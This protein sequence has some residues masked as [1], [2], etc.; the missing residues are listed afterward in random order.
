MSKEN[1]ATGTASPGGIA[2][3]LFSR[4]NRGL[5]LDI[6]V[7]LVNVFLMWALTPLFL[8]VI[9]RALAEEPLAL[10]IVFIMLTAV[11]VLPPAGAILKRHSY[12]RR[13]QRKENF[14]IISDG[15]AGCFFN[16][17]FYFC[18]QIVIVSAINAFVVHYL[19]GLN[20]PGPE[21]FFTSLF[22][23]LVLAIV[24]TVF[25][26]R[27]FSPPKREPKSLFLLSD[28]AELLGDACIFAN[29][30]IYQLVWNLLTT[31]E[32]FGYVSSVSEFFGRLF[33]LSFI[34]FLIYFPPRIFY[35]AEDINKARTWFTMFLANSPVIL[36]VLFGG[37]TGLFFG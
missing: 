18:L 12:H 30:L 28:N 31:A 37:D 16:P 34:A 4:N 15:A 26:Y 7:F 19:L 1:N 5:L 21:I 24:N 6:T 13:R 27:C 14:D 25:V 36:R 29:M 9:K 17:I 3:Q 35:L 8:L 11:L 23:L 32:M 2:A 10:I 33:F 22:I 20:D